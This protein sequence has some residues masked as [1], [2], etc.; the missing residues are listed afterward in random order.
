MSSTAFCHFSLKIV[1]F[2][3]LCYYSDQCHYLRNCEPT[4]LLTQ[5][6]STDGFMLGQETGGCAAGQT[7]TFIQIIFQIPMVTSH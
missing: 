1:N 6:L 3:A 2:L 7:L 5:Q 4:N